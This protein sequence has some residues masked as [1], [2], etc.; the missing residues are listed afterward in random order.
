MCD[1]AAGHGEQGE[2]GEVDLRKLTE[3]QNLEDKDREEDGVEGI[4][5]INTHILQLSSVQTH[6]FTM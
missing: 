1:F 4:L 6:L 5:L 3:Q 2:D